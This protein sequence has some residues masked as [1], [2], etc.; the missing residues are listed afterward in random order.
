MGVLSVKII[1]CFLCLIADL[2]TLPIR[3]LTVI[4]RYFYN[5]AITKEK[6]PLCKYLLT[7]GVSE[8]NLR[9]GHVYMQITTV[10]KKQ[11]GKRSLNK[12]GDTFFFTESAP[13]WPFDDGIPD[14][15]MIP[16]VVDAQIRHMGLNIPS[17]YPTSDEGLQIDNK[18][19]L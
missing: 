7:T 2:L 13:E 14:I 17:A 19:V 6:H 10:E 18:M 1:F 9:S 4:P 5:K 8:E 11:N 12:I 16:D 3:T 15:T